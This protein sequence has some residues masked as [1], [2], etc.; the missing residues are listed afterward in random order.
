MRKEWLYLLF[1]AGPCLVLTIASTDLFNWKIGV[2]KSIT[3]FEEQTGLQRAGSMFLSP[4][5]SCGLG[6]T[7]ALQPRLTLT[8]ERASS[9]HILLSFNCLVD[10]SLWVELRLRSSMWP[11]VTNPF[12]LSFT[13]LE[14]NGL[15][16][17]CGNGTHL[18]F[19]DF[20]TSLTYLTWS[21]FAFGLPVAGS[22]NCGIVQPEHVILGSRRVPHTNPI[23]KCLHHFQ[24]G[25]FITTFE[26]SW[27]SHHSLPLSSLPRGSR[28]NCRRCAQ[29]AHR[30]DSM[31]EQTGTF[32]K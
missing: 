20:K 14:W 21:N 2:E 11:Q 27:H 16:D 3:T 10:Q 19:T 9:S 24:W 4:N 12:E 5:S 15:V 1:D 6:K 32:F 13:S 7:W 22:N 28:T 26:M 31:A 17:K 18:T 25:S 29:F 23:R 30:M 8:V